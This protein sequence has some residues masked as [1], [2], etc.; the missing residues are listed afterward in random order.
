MW[1]YI[2]FLI[3][4][5]IVVY[6]F[7]IYNSLIKINNKVKEA[8]ST[9][10]V[11]LK[12][13]WDLIPN[14]VELVKEYKNYE[15]DTLENIISLRN[16]IYDDMSNEDKLKKNEELNKGINKIMILAENHPDLKAI[17]GFMNLSN[18]LINIENDIAN[19]R[20]YYNAVVR[21]YNNKVEIFPNNFIANV[22]GYKIKKMFESSKI[23]KE[24]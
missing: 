19:S 8:F 7:I 14:I 23:E 11:Y 16:N 20:K 22:F 15:K 6:V 13:R 18:Q 9:M 3:L 4:F 5:L 10:D 17:E 24:I 2:L 12:K 21:I 1:M